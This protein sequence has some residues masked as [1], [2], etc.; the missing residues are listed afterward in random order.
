SD[1]L[2]FLSQP[3]SIIVGRQWA[4]SHGLSVG[5]QVALVTPPGRRAFPVRGLVE[6]RGLAST[7]AG[8]VVVMDLYAAERAF[9]ADGQISQIDLVLDGGADVERGRGAVAAIPQPGC[10]AEEP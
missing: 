7:L 10:A 1:L 2:G 3:D 6:P 9:T 5:D 4:S 8:R